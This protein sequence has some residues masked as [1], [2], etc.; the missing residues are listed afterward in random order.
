MTISSQKKFALG[1]RLIIRVLTLCLIMLAIIAFVFLSTL[2]NTIDTLRDRDLI[3]QAEDIIRHLD[4][5]NGWQLQLPTELSQ[6]YEDSKGGYR[7]YISTENGDILFASPED[8]SL[9]PTTY[10]EGF[11]RFQNEQTDETFYGFGIAYQNIFIQVAQ[12]EIHSDVITDTLLDE[13]LDHGAWMILPFIIALLG[14]IAWTI[15]TSLKPVCQASDLAAKISPAHPEIRLPTAD[16]PNEIIPMVH[17]INLA[18]DRMNI[19]LEQQRNFTANAAHEL[20]TPLTIIRTQIDNIENTIDTTQKDKITSL[21]KDVDHMGRIIAQLLSESQLEQSSI[22]ADD[23]ADLHQI[24]IDVVSAM[25]P[26]ALKSSRDIEIIGGAENIVKGRAEIISPAIRNLVENALEFTPKNTTI[27]LDLHQKGQISVRDRGDGV[28]P[29]HQSHIFER[30]WR[31]PNQQNRNGSGLGLSI[32]A[33]IMH[34][35]KGKV[36]ISNAPLDKDGHKGAIFTLIFPLD[37]LP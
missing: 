33:N 25:A 12:G 2:A 18:L 4:N 7:Y 11:F 35:H 37:L 32:V 5:E 14:L 19:A 10:K 17:A 24:A 9:M 34:L 1:R 15:R 8:I 36:T 26:I 29:A 16:I 28:L 21:K 27:T 13:T 6:T 20:R 22:N 30:F 23:T 3:G 31:A